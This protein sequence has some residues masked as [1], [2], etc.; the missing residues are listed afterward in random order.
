MSGTPLRVGLI[1]RGSIG[2]KVIAAMDSGVVPGAELVGVA[3]SGRQSPDAWTDRRLCSLPELIERSELIVEAAGQRAVAEHGPAVVGSGV[4]LLILSVGALVDEELLARL[5]SGPGR[6]SVCTGAIGGL[7]L[8]RA[9]A[10]GG[11]LRRV[12]MTSAKRPATL[13]QDWMDPELVD[14]LRAGTERLEVGRGSPVEVARAFPKSANVAAAVALAAGS[15]ELVEVVMVADPAAV[16]TRHVIEVDS[17]CGE[18]RFD[19]TH[20]T[21]PDNPATAAIVPLAVLRALRD[22]AGCG[23]GLI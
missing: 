11:A 9:A 12:G 21:S 4:D 22:L 13:I 7:E 16:R 19:L 6:M 23:D 2:R 1:G 3:A 5:R 20:D 17:S 15:S 14:R 10:V 8:I 18:Y